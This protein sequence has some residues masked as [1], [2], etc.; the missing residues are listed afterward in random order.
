MTKLGLNKKLFFIQL[1]CSFRT[2]RLYIDPP[3]YKR[4]SVILH[5]RRLFSSFFG[6]FFISEYCCKRQLSK[7]KKIVLYG[8]GRRL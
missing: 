3:I 7:K 6:S 2:V 5:L 8:R 1:R 4:K